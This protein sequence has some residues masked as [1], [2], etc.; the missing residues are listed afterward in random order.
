MWSIA[1]RSP[2]NYKRLFSGQIWRKQR[3][4]TG[5]EEVIIVEDYVT[6][7][8]TFKSVAPTAQSTTTIVTANAGGSI[9]ITDILL[10]VK[11]K[12][13]AVVTLQFTDGT[14]VEVLYAADVTN[15]ELYLSHTVKGRMQGW[16]DARLD[17]V[18]A[19][20]DVDVNC[21][22]VYMQ[23]PNSDLLFADWDALR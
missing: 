22:I 23:V 3:P 1:L 21:T 15:G 9:V 5:E 7:F 4:P 11:K 18:I 12:N 13:S 10:A 14:N 20:A 19:G 8:S 16:K 2:V 17:L 6:A